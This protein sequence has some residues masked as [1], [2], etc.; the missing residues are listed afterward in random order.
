MRVA[1][2]EKVEAEK[3]LQIKKAEGARN[4]S[5]WLVWILSNLRG[6]RHF[7]LREHAPKFKLRT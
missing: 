1:A 6:T 7:S 4:P 2:N 3:I 5:T